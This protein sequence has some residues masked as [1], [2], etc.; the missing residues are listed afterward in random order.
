MCK[1]CSAWIW[2]FHWDAYC[3]PATPVWNL[4]YLS[5]FGDAMIYVLTATDIEDECDTVSLLCA[6]TDRS[7]V[8][9]VMAKCEAILEKQKQADS[10]TEQHM[11]KWTISDPRPSTECPEIY[12]KPTTMSRKDWE[13][14][15]ARLQWQENYNNVHRKFKEW[16]AR[17]NAERAAYFQTRIE[18][19]LAV[20]E[21]HLYQVVSKHAYAM[22]E[23]QQVA[24]TESLLGTVEMQSQT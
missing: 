11:V 10:E 1:G 5:F 22:L 3:P 14:H 8:E 17:Y 2:A 13:K 21:K 24:M 15:P 19:H 16:Y 7:Q 18:L 20:D 9:E 23:I 4:G 12:R 6:S